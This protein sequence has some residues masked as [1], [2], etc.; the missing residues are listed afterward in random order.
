MSTAD[1]R[2]PEAEARALADVRT[3]A[4]DVLYLLGAHGVEVLFLNPG[5]DSAPIQEAAATLAER[6]VPA[7]RVV[8]CSFEAVAL[9][10]AHGYWQATGRP[11]AVWVHVDAGTQNLGSMVHNVLRDR[12]GVVVLAGRTP[13]GEA[14]DDP[15]G[16]DTAIHWPQDV[17]DQAGIVR[18]YAKWTAELVRAQDAPRVVGRAVQVAGGGIPGLAYL[19]IS[20]DVLMEPAAPA[21]RR[22]LDGWARPHPPALAPEAVREIADLVAGASRPVLVT[23]RIGRRP[24]G[25]AAVARFAEVAAVPVVGRPEAL[26]VRADHPMARTRPED[27]G[28]LLEEADV[29]VVVEADVPWIPRGTRLAEGVRVVHVDP[30]PLHASMPLWTYPVDV[31]ATA[32]GD[33]AL[34][35]L[36]DALEE[37][38]AAWEERRAALG[39]TFGAAWEERRARLALEGAARHGPA[40]GAATSAG[41]GAGTGAV[42]GVAGGTGTRRLRP[43][44]VLRVLAEALDPEDVVVEEAV[45][46]A[47]A[48]ATHLPRFLPGTLASAGGPGLGWALGASV[49]IRMARPDRRVVAVVGDGSFMFAVPTAALCLAAEAEAPF[50]TVILDNDGYRA[51]R[52][53]VFALFPEGLSAEAGEAIGT[54]F[55]RPPDFAAVAEACGALGQT[56]ED[57]AGLRKALED[58]FEAVAGG[59]SAVVAARIERR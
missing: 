18:G 17:P 48:V 25:A 44:D 54:R 55:R 16:R 56:A 51:S 34:A 7:P 5:T 52:Q 33:V 30:D 23:T 46:N 31:S 53:P 6:G 12:A 21:A 1:V 57:E 32:D 58:A 19:T 13:Y 29:V 3:C 26:N 28:P 27:A 24:G 35:Q 2:V 15:G 40:T 22:R 37:R 11:Q 36:A 4:E 42:A 20:R 10:A 8:G 43:A 50:V 39:A 45:T 14:P 47:G 59:R 38:R 9:A 41:T 49:G